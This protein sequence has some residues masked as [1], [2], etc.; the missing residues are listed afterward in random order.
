MLLSSISLLSFPYLAGQL[1]D[2]ALDGQK[3][4]IEP[5][6]ILSIELR[7]ILWYM[8]IAAGLQAFF[9]YGRMYYS[10]CLSERVGLNLKQLTYDRLIRLPIQFYDAHRI[11]DLLSRLQTDITLIQQ[12]VASSLAEGLR[13]ISIIG[14]GVVLIF[15][16]APQLSLLLLC[17]LPFF[18]LLGWY[19][20]RI[21]R[22]VSK[23]RQEQQGQNS[24]TAEESLQLIATIKSFTAER[25][26]SNRYQEQQARVLSI[27]MHSVRQRSLFIALM[28]LLMLTST[29]L[30]LAYGADL[31][32]KDQL[33]TGDLL[34]FVLY[35]TFIGG[36]VA[37]LGDLYGQAQKIRGAADRLKELFDELPEDRHFLQGK[38]PFQM[39]DVQIQNL[40][41]TYPTRLK[42]KP[43]AHLSLDIPQGKRIALIGPSGSGKSTLTKLLLRY[44][45]PSEG[46][47]SINN[48]NIKDYPLH[49]LRSQIGIV[50]QEPILF[51]GSIEENIR[52]GQPNASKETLLKAAEQAHVMEFAD[53]MPEGLNTLIGD[54]GIKLSGGQRQRIAIARLILKNPAFIILDEATSSLDSAS[55]QQ[56]QEALKEVMSERT[57]LIIAHRLATIRTVDLIYIIKEGQL[58]EQGTH[59]ELLNNNGLYKEFVAMQKFT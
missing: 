41:F 12:G 53:R 22:R 2:V 48:T 26:Q 51:G 28:I 57:C 55:E 40:S 24:V 39:G 17:V 11:G 34:S 5:R 32:Q 47:I 45:D 3:T 59:N 1:L 8:L 49:E 36:S 50:P 42:V 21:L 19:F 14:A 44:Y 9:S 35:T 46:Q 30:L 13:Q 10:G 27:S 15:S 54:Q 52:Y 56:V 43:I 18:L 58:I 25:L 4:A 29:S 37:S 38:K 31:V 23:E 20:G 16:I 33:N 7:E 6:A